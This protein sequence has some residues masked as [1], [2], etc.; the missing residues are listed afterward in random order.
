MFQRCLRDKKKDTDLHPF[1][2]LGP[3]CP[4]IYYPRNVKE[5]T[6]ILQGC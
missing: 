5:C 2:Y 1:V 6:G 3:D 4:T